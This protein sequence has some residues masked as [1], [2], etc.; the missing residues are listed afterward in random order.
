VTA[1]RH[2]LDGAFGAVEVAHRWPVALAVE[3]DT[4][5]WNTALGVDVGLGIRT[6]VALLDWQH[7]S[8]GAGWSVAL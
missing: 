4:E 2:V 5:K 8:F 6:R 3:Y 1:S 7:V